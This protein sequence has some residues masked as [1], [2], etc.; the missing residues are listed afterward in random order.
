M[1]HFGGCPRKNYRVAVLHPG[2]PIE[3]TIPDQRSREQYRDEGTCASKA[4]S[5][6]NPHTTFQRICVRSHSQWEDIPVM[7]TAVPTVSR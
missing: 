4:G 7:R 5:H 2:L 6:G 3:P 1:D